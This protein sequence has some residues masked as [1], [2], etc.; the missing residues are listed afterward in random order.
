MAGETPPQPTQ[1]VDFNR[2]FSYDPTTGIITSRGQRVVVVGT[3]QF[4]SLRKSMLAALPW[5]EVKA[6]FT[7][8]G[9]DQGFQDALNIAQTMQ[10]DDDFDFVKLGTAM[11]APNG[12]ARVDLEKVEFNLMEGRVSVRARFLS[13]Q[14]AVD[15]LRVV[16]PAKEG[17]CWIVAGYAYGF[18]EALLDLPIYVQEYECLAMGHPVCR[19]LITT[20]KAE[21]AAVSVKGEAVRTAPP[22]AA[23]AA[24]PAVSY[25][26]LL[27]TVS[28]IAP[29][30][31]DRLA[32]FYARK[33]AE[34]ERTRLNYRAL[35]DASPD[36][37]LEVSSEGKILM[38]NEPARALTG[39]A[40]V[41]LQGAPLASLF[42]EAEGAEVSRFLSTF[43]GSALAILPRL[44]ARH[45]SGTPRLVELIM[46]A[47]PSTGAPATAVVELRDVTERARLE[48]QIRDREARL[49]ALFESAADGILVW[50]EAGAITEA[51][52]A[53]E[54]ILG[55][56]PGT[57]R[58]VPIE[59]V[60]HSTKS[61]V[62]G[63]RGA[64]STRLRG[65]KGV[66][67]AKRWVGDAVLARKGGET[68]PA[69]LSVTPL[70]TD[71]GSGSRLALIKDL[72]EVEHLR[73][74]LATERVKTD[75]IV[76]AIAAPMVI[77]DAHGNLEWRNVHAEFA[78][79][80]R[81][82]V[83][84]SPCHLVVCEE[85]EPCEGCPVAAFGAS[86]QNP[87]TI[88]HERP[89]RTTDGGAHPFE[90]TLR[91]LV[92]HG[93][94]PSTLVLFRDTSAEAGRARVA[95][96]R[97]RRD[98]LTLD[99]SD[100]LL[101]ARALPDM[102]ARFSDRS[103]GAL[104]LSLLAVLLKAGEDWLHPLAVFQGGSAIADLP[105][106]I[107]AGN[108]GVKAVM[109]EG[110]TAVIADAD[111]SAGAS[112]LL[113]V[114]ERPGA[115]PSG[116]LAIVALRGRAGD[117]IGA[118][119]A[120]RAEIDAFE[121]G[122]V[123]SLEEVGARLGLA[124]D[125]VLLAEANR[126]LLKL[127]E[128]LLAEAEVMLDNSDLQRSTRRY[129]EILAEATGSPAVGV[130]YADAAN[131]RY[132]LFGMYTPTAGHRGG[133]ARAFPAPECLVVDR[134]AKARDLTIVE[135]RSLLRGERADPV[136]KE[137]LGERA[138]TVV[139]VP[140]EA[141]DLSGLIVLALPP[142]F[143]IST[144][145]ELEALRTLAQ[146]TRLSI[147]AL[148]AAGRTGDILDLVGGSQ[149]GRS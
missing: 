113:A 3:T 139:L 2:L 102:L 95:R 114:L 57:L 37:V 99:V 21:G 68:T 97:L 73:E 110:E 142:T 58:G 86:V 118:L 46:K 10:M 90:L 34:L 25:E 47:I 81:R 88:Q 147:T 43:E 56:A 124:L 24:R 35:I 15:H 108:T 64:P 117:L 51:N 143:R 53:A 27:Q 71:A 148:A 133:A 91:R 22:A 87:G 54:R 17:V 9:R 8:A 109:K 16:G 136:L 77:F 13:S 59:T 75:A 82:L 138:E 93:R 29:A 137:F 111:K 41:E 33:D 12:R 60:V 145:A 96:D 120:G 69:I 101:S 106:R 7:K 18:V 149:K 74:A 6:A 62:G 85:V 126:R 61:N 103:A 115:P 28:E 50:T 125:G 31:R 67:L 76:D 38:A 141:G 119:V 129:M 94:D 123:G 40:P 39:R 48:G 100:I 132:H 32:N 78:F 135:T 92:E 11:V 79:G 1:G 121:E 144:E 80:R 70:K 52:P 14:E 83:Q 146:Q 84:G 72:R 127:Q 19:I 42:E 89:L 116:S 5:D 128:A 45:P 107:P 112:S 131:G 122:D 98:D 36:V 55:Y 104:K 134:A 105:P 130:V 65:L 26:Q 63:P 4:G 44:H 30:E 49:R 23:E 20:D 66:D 140:V